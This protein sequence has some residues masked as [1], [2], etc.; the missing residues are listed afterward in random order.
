MIIS[1]LTAMAERIHDAEGWDL[2][3]ASSRETRN[4]FWE[5]VV[6]CAYWGHPAYN[7]SPDKQ[8]HCKDP[9]GPSGG[10]PASD[11]VAV[12]LPSRQ[13]WDCIPGA[14]GAGYRFEAD[15]VPF[16]LPLDQFV[17]VPSKPAGWGG[18]EPAVP[19]PAYP[20][21]PQNEAD[22]DGAGVALFEDF[23]EANT[24]RPDDPNTKPNP[25][26][27]R[28]AFRVAYDWLTKQTPD[29]PASV[30][31]HRVLW[32]GLLGLPPQP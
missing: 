25:R 6:G 13:A 15:A 16:I 3:A 9:D 23:M 1:E 14:G 22:I 19:L 31:K 12:S 4:A 32:R 29:L 18:A 17:F 28:F 24:K 7:A 10:R 27:F 11:D 5:R 26:M 21:Y 20:G 8:W 2:G 30:T